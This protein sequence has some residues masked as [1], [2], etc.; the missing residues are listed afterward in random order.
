MSIIRFFSLSLL[1]LLSIGSGMARTEKTVNGA[2]RQIGGQ[3]VRIEFYSPSIVRVTKTIINGPKAKKSYSVI[4]RPEA[5]KDLKESKAGAEVTLSSPC[6]RV[7]LNTSN[8]KI[9]FA[10]KKNERLLTDTTTTFDKRTD[11]ANEGQ[12]KIRQT[13][14]LEKDEAIYGLGQL[15]DTHMNQRGRHVEIW[16]HNTY[17]SIPYFTSEKGYGVYWDNAGKSYFDD[18]EAGTSFTS[19]TG[20]AADY[21]F[22]YK[23]GTQDG[24]IAGIRTL[25]GKATMFPL[26][27]MGFWQSRERYKTSDELAG[28][29]DKYRELKIPVDAMV[30]DW[31]YW[32]C[33]SN[34]NAMRFQNPYY[35]NKVG[36]P[37][38]AKYLPKDLKNKKPQGEPRLKTPEEMVNYVH[39]NDAHLMITIWPDFGPW[40]EQY[41]ELK[42]IHAL[43][44]FDTWPRNAGALV[45][46]VFNPK[47]REIYWKHLQYLYNMGFDAWWTDS[48]EPDHFEKAGDE[49]YLTYDGSWLSVKN[50]FSLVHNRSIYEHQ[51]AMK[52]NDKRSVQMTRSGAF[53]LQHYGTFSWSG[54]IMATWDEM[55]KQVPSGL[56]YILCGIPMW[57]TDISGF[58][59]GD[60]KN[61]P[62]NVAV[63]ELKVRWMEW[64][65]FMPLMRTHCSSPMLS[66]IYEMGHQGDWAYDAIVGAIKLRYRLL[67]YTY[68]NLGDCV[69][70]D[71]SM[72][73]PLVMDFANDQKASRLN[74]EY[75]FGRNLLV[76]PITDPMFTWKDSKRNGHL[77][78][79]DVKQAAA[80]VKVYLPKGTKWYD[81]WDN[82]VYEGGEDIQRPCSI[83][84]MPVFVK[85]GTIMPFGPDVQYSNE[86]PWDSLEI[87]VYPGENGNYTLY[88]D[89]GDNYDYEKGQFSEI[90]FSWDDKA[91][92]L[93]ISPRRGS[94]K[95]MLKDRTF[96]IVLVDKN[97]GN[98]RESM[99]V[100]TSVRYNGK[101]LTVAL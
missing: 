89:E 38:W 70:H 78:Y 66:E 72:M 26:W 4:M 27:T 32:G 69:Q 62:K 25:T 49:N 58:F 47:A 50:A 93:T 23:D 76:K 46:D 21:Y 68:S 82:T 90:T 42:A 20:T 30:Q 91:H 74:D 31:Q 75:L 22:I 40:T 80:P 84:I 86:K 44:P 88:E 64:G 15:R 101:K 87:R 43:L 34:W 9:T 53:G 85:A 39:R 5:V 55:K 24:V 16:N 63:Q 35:I 97:S 14:L 13:W 37:A 57:N 60:Y 33:D 1:L 6:I 41:K 79:P 67:P 3:N 12:Y 45:Y 52:G 92:R 81:F 99:K 96:N 36:D 29:L 73:R 17:I 95:G 59:Y 94:F 54:D 8:G 19:E 10:D 56:N 100:T 28:V 48:T 11:K 98:G 71:G 7:T 18:N 65:T 77:I 61:D 83:D 51:R 2:E